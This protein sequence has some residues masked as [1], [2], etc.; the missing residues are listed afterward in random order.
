MDHLK[1]L[2][3]LLDGGLKAGEPLRSG[4]LALVPLHGGKAGP[5]YLLA[6]DVIA[7]GQLTIRELPG[8]SVPE[9]VADN[10][11]DQAVLILDGEHLEGAMQDRVLNTSVLVGARRK[12][13][14]PVSCVESGRWHYEERG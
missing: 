7:S 8:A 1:D 11:A 5:D 9:L 6:A 4:P 10:A 14:L 13:M 3:Q 2:T 12:T